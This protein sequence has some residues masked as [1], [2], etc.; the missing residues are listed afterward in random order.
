MKHSL[1]PA[2]SMVVALTFMACQQS[3]VQTLT[4][5]SKAIG[6][7]E[8]TFDS[9]T[10]KATA[11]V[12]SGNQ[13]RAVQTSTNVTFSAPAALGVLTD[14]GN[15]LQYI[16]AQF[17]VNNLLP[18][19]LSDLTLVAF[20][21]TG[22]MGGTALKSVFN[23]ANSSIYP[24][25][26][27]AGIAFAQA[28]KPANAPSS[29]AP[30]FVVNNAGADLQLFLESELP[31]LQTA[32][33][34]AGEI[35]TAGG[36]YLLPY[37]FVARNGGSSR[38][39][40]AST[41]AAGTVNIAIQVPTSNSSPAT[42]GYRFTMTFVIFD[43]PVTTRVSES[44]QEQGAGSGA[45]T[46][47]T[48]FTS[49]Q[50][51][52]V[53]GSS[54]LQTNDKLVNACRVR[55][56]GTA[57]SPTAFLTTAPSTVAG[58]FDQ[59]FA[60]AGKRQININGAGA[61]TANGSEKITSMAVQ[62]DG[63]IVLA[64]WATFTASGGDF[65]VMR[66]NQDGSFDR[67]FDTDGKATFSVG[68]GAS[69]DE[70][71]AIL[72]Q[73]D[74]KI[75]LG[76]CTLCNST[77]S[78]FAMIRVNTNGSQDTTGFASATSGNHI[79]D[80]FGDQDNITG[81]ALQTVGGVNYIV[82]A[83]FARENNAGS[84]T[85]NPSNQH[86]A[87]F[88]LRVSDGTLDTGFGV[89]GYRI[90][91]YQGSSATPLSGTLEDFITGVVVDTNNK[92]IIGGSDGA[93]TAGVIRFTTTGAWDMKA[94]SSFGTGGING[95]LLQGG[96]TSAIVFGGAMPTGGTNS[97]DFFAMK[98][99]LPSGSTDGT[100]DTTWGNQSPKTGRSYITLSANADTARAAAFQSDGKI[101]LAGRLRTGGGT[102]TGDVALARLNVD[103]TTDISFDTDGIVSVQRQ[104]GFT[105]EAYATAVNAGKIVVAGF[106]RFNINAP[107][108]DDLF[109]LQ[110]NP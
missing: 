58:S 102:S 19:T 48:S 106:E 68:G 24:A 81:L 35:S 78:N 50:I 83:G 40:N 98:F 94:T 99:N 25:N 46:R 87:L 100:L 36:E 74:G 88:R 71:H 85:G 82:A 18:S 80:R 108:Q 76:G 96:G 23:F 65:L 9:Q 15:S 77:T 42:T 28:V 95:V 14:V 31:S 44:L 69:N 92:I 27:A 17:N 86:G 2:I 51:A 8:L 57:A 22:N 109:V 1:V 62:P 32:A 89:S 61:S 45:I 13:T 30:S 66:L 59:C 10:N 12:H 91:S 49:N 52:A 73:S 54:L 104:I 103:G 4:P 90:F 97:N 79:A 55:T 43:A 16:N 3:P 70:S 105:D 53:V 26:D 63:K 37:G 11:L 60:A 20:Q 75:V 67:T 34:T 7:L 41:N 5:S 47:S 21:K 29:V 72:I 33:N 6:T 107:I 93:F 84:A 64:G 101:I 39:L 110:F 56:A 38:T